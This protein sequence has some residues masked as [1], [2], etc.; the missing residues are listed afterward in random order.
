[1]LYKKRH[2]N[3]FRKN[4]LILAHS[5]V[6]T[7]TSSVLDYTVCRDRFLEHRIK[8][9][10]IDD[11]EKAIKEG[12]RM[13]SDEDCENISRY[14]HINGCYEKKIGNR[15]TTAFGYAGTPVAVA[16]WQ[17]MAAIGWTD[18]DGSVEYNCGGTI[19]SERFIITA[20]HCRI[21]E[22]KAPDTVRV[23][24]RFLKTEWDDFNA[25]QLSIEKFIVHPSYKSFKKYHDIALIKTGE[26]IKFSHVVAPACILFDDEEAKKH[27]ISL[28]IAGY[29]R[30][31]I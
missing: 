8:K 11:L 21:Y 1:V 24:D 12:K 16:D 19:V 22:G 29:G 5:A 20:A 10:I 15:T 9:V 30:V 26:L 27:N 14:S 18:S 23:G 25:Q 6:H 13:I 17:N 2:S 28:F 7:D 3:N 31:S 4:F